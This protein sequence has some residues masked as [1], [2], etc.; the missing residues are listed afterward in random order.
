MPAVKRIVICGGGL[1]GRLTAAMLTKQ[2]GATAQITLVDCDDASGSDLFYGSVTSP[3]AYAFN[4]AAGVPEPR[5]LLDTNAAFSWGTRFAGWGTGR[6]SWM[7]CFHLP[8]PV[9]NGVQLHHYL[10]RIGLQEL[11]PFLVTAAVAQQGVFAHPLETGAGLLKR[12]EYGYQFDPASYPVPFTRAAQGSTFRMVRAQIA[13]VACAGENIAGLRLSSGELLAADLY[14]DCT[15]TRAVLISRVSGE[16]VRGR[17]VRAWV[18]VEAR[19]G[20]GAPYRTVTAHDFGWQS[21]T[22]LQG[23][24]LR[25]TVSHPEEPDSRPLAAH[26][27]TPQQT[28]DVTIGW[29]RQPWTRNCVALGHAAG[30]V[31]PLTPAPMLLLQRDIERLLWL[32][33]QSDEMSVERREFNRQASEDH[34]HANLF[35][36]AL[37]DAPPEPGLRYW[38]DAA[39]PMSEKLARK[40]ELFESRGVLVAY[41]L[42]P[43]NAEDWSIL[44]YGMGRRPLRYDRVADRESEPDI[45]RFLAGLQGEIANLAKS[46]PSQDEYLKGL[47]R[48]LR[49]SNW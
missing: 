25:F 39:D 6:R 46:L 22:P 34:E 41:D 26:A 49:N 45:R 38:H 48:Y 8:L 32:I 43:M 15:G 30:V 33:P 14:V 16:E 42:E 12:A 27:T 20:A 40:I 37:L 29:R 13:E 47:I 5:L 2:L 21:D 9:I 35:H 36:R 28:A 1:A 3:T 18:T 4:L 31:E 7:Q 11:E 23:A 10:Q 19:N 44:H 24:S 17:R